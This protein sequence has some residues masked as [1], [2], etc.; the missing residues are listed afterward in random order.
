[1]VKL[2]TDVIEKKYSQI[3]SSKSLS[4]TMKKEELWK[5][6]H[7]YMNDMFIN[8]ID[9][10]AVCRSL[11]TIYLQNNNISQI[12][13]LH[14]ASNLTH[15]YLQHNAITKLENLGSL[16]NLQKLYLGHNNITIVEGLE[17]IKKLQEL[18]IESQKI[19]LGESLCFEPRSAFTLSMCLKFLDIS[20]N[21]MASLKDLSRFHE[22][23]TLVA[24][25]NLIDDVND[26]TA[27]ISTLTSLKDL[28]LQGN[29]VTWSY[30]YRETLIANSVSLANLDGK[31]VTD[32][33]RSF[34]KR[35]QMEKY[36]R[37]TKKA[38]KT[39]LKDDITSSLNLSAAFKR[40]ISRAIFQ[41]P[42]PQLSITIASGENQLQVFPP[43]KSAS[44]IKSI[45]DNHVM[46]RP[47]WSNVTKRK[48]TRLI[49]SNDETIALPLI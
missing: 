2:T 16:Q 38:T 47:F 5:L 44:G 9:D 30:R 21:K 41:H 17:N 25:N 39:L 23:D 31:I 45:K 7:L 43:W 46:P 28:S 29:P 1:M 6:T 36:N 13:N 22:L 27:T 48:E 10:L 12:K 26:L 14:F 32:I 3:L 37:L 35:F 33:C 49:R 4:K 34:M 40:S 8:S 19:P 42:G 18:H 15:L 24:K 11:K 20:D